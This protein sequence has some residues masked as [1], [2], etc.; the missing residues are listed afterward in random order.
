[1]TANRAEASPF[2][3]E[4]ALDP[5]FAG[6]MRRTWRANSGGSGNGTVRL[7]LREGEAASRGGSGSA[8]TSMLSKKTPMPLN[9]ESSS[10]F[11]A[12]SPARSSLNRQGEYRYDEPGHNPGKL[13][14]M[15]TATG[16]TKSYSEKDAVRDSVSLSAKVRSSGFSGPNGA[17]NPQP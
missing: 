17:E 16:L 7:P 13:L 14:L 10:R 12:E 8:R 11:L 9:A 4:A 2:L 5:Q 1:V 6:R 15:I 3:R